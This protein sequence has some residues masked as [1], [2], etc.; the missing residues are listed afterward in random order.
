MIDT[1]G[2]EFLTARLCIRK[3][4]SG[5]EQSE[6]RIIIFNIIRFHSES[7]HKT[8]LI[9]GIFAKVGEQTNCLHLQS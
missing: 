2:E 1:A 9:Y 7:Q 3:G 5:E 8:D 6:H 4:W